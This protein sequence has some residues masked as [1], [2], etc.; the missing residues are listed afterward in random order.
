MKAAPGPGKGLVPS[1]REY[2]KWYEDNYGIT[3]HM[4]ISGEMPPQL[5]STDELQLV[6]IIQEALT[7]I[8]KH[9]RAS[10]VQ[11]AFLSSGDRDLVEITDDGCG[12][13]TCAVYENHYGLNIMRERAE[14]FGGRVVIKSAPGGGT[15]VTIWLPPG[16]RSA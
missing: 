2:L 9:A 11:V 1:L 5:T 12:F 16:Q 7:N 4:K 10:L 6:R 14:A 8:R 13:D 15:R 3:V